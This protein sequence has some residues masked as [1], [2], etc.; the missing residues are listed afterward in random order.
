MLKVTP[1]DEEF[2]VYD[3]DGPKDENHHESH[4]QW[5]SDIKRGA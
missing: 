3:V 4:N 5:P 2:G 1:S